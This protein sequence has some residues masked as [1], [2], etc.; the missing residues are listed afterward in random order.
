V[1]SSLKGELLMQSF[2]CKNVCVDMGW[3]SSSPD[4]HHTCCECDRM[5]PVLIICCTLTTSSG[6]C[7]VNR[8][9]LILIQ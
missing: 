8:I 7:H 1:N 4:P 2:M 6:Q 5:W 3:V 9:L